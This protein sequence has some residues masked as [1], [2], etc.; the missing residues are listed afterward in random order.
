MYLIFLAIFP[1]LD[2]AS[3]TPPC[4]VFL[5][6]V[7]VMRPGRGPT[8]WPAGSGK[9]TVGIYQQAMAFAMANC[10]ADIRSMVGPEKPT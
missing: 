8:R 3:G 5:M 6:R 9:M 4:S 10:P 2:L 7:G 1:A